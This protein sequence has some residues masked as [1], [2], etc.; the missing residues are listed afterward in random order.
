ML[1]KGQVTFCGEPGELND[2]DVF[3]SYLSHAV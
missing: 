2:D 1:N 3:A